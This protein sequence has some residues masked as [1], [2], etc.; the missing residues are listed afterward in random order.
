MRCDR[1]ERRSSILMA[2]SW[3]SSCAATL[4]HWGQRV[5]RQTPAQRSQARR[6]V[7]EIGGRLARVG[8][9]YMMY[10]PILSETLTTACIWS[11]SGDTS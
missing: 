9:L 6:G 3:H 10:E 8:P 7:L 5:A 4:G 2:G 1:V 11:D